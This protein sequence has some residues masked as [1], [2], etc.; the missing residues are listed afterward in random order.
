MLL[1]IVACLEG[2]AKT[3]ALLV[4]NGTTNVDARVLKKTA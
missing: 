2:D 3:L 4:S 1:T